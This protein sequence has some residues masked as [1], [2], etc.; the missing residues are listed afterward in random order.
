LPN[1]KLEPNELVAGADALAD[2][3]ADPAAVLALVD[4]ELKNG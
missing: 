1:D 4:P 2:A 3:V